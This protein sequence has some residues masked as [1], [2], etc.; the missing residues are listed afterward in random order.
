MT[1]E[2]WENLIVG[3]GPYMGGAAFI[4]IIQL[5][6]VKNI[7]DK[8]TRIRMLVATVIFQM[9]ALAAGMIVPFL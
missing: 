1:P 9:I 7:S 3:T 2:F 5:M 6:V 8:T 4:G